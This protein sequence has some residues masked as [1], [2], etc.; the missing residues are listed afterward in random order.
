MT[1]TILPEFAAALVA[2]QGEFTTIAKTAD[3]PF[4]KSKYAPLAS[5]V[6]AATPILH[7]HGLAVVQ[8]VGFFD[9]EDTL[10]TIVFH[11]S[12]DSFQDTMRLHLVK[13]DP[14]A[15]GSAI[16]YA[17]R[18]SYMAALGLVADVDDDANQATAA[19]NRQPR[20]EGKQWGHPTSNS[21][22]AGESAAYIQAATAKQNLIDAFARAGSDTESAQRQAKEAWG[23]RGRNPIPKGAL[24]EMIASIGQR[25]D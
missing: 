8:T 6:E 19:V 24:A 5:V 9:G 13:D 15:H 21:E 4:F 12:G 18:Q 23:D 7:K 17:R 10:T 22:R 25:L 14:Q 20:P 2:A 1:K 11:K 3:N 16:T